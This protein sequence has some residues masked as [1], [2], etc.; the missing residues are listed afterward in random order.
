MNSINPIHHPFTFGIGSSGTVTPN[1]FSVTPE[2][3][4]AAMASD[5]VFDEFF[6]A[7]QS[8]T[9]KATNWQWIR[10]LADA[11]NTKTSNAEPPGKGCELVFRFRQAYGDIHHMALGTLWRSREG[12]LEAGFAHQESIPDKNGTFRGR[13]FNT[14]DTRSAMGGKTPPVLNSL[15][16]HGLPDVLVLPCPAPENVKVAEWLSDPGCE[17]PYGFDG[18]E[19]AQGFH[20]LTCFAVTQAVHRSVQDR[21]AEISTAPSMPDIFK[22][23]MNDVFGDGTFRNYTHFSHRGKTFEVENLPEKDRL[24]GFIALGKNWG[25]HEKWDVQPP[26][27]TWGRPKF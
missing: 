10:D 27:P 23:L 5:P 7:P 22:E 14:F 19:D 15:L 21:Q 13:V 12:R 6:A 1:G 2:E 16:E 20:A 8:G 3:L 9:R 17:H 24:K 11:I 4:H 26:M 25:N 18:K